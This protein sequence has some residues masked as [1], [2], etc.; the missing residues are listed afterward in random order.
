LNSSGNF[1]P[2]LAFSS[3]KS[4]NDPPISSGT[5]ANF[6]EPRGAAGQ[7]YCFTVSKCSAFMP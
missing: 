5:P 7:G 1:I 6:C 2:R 3:P 4:E